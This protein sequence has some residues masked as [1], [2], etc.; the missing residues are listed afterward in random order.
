MVF[1]NLCLGFILTFFYPGDTLLSQGLFVF[2]RIFS[3]QFQ[4]HTLL[5]IKEI[6]LELM[7]N[8]GSGYLHDEE[9]VP[10]G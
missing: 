9:F 7:I 6:E 4:T 3:S 2:Q 8:L 1:L 5:L 10:Y